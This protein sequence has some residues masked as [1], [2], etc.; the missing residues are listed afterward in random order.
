M[1]IPEGKRVYVDEAC[2][3]QHLLPELPDN[4]SFHR[5]KRLNETEE[6]HKRKIIFL[7]PYPPELNL[8]EYLGHWLK[9]KKAGCLKFCSGLNIALS[10]AI[11]E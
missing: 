10:P 11:Q 2:F 1:E 5:K 7:P 4:A 6:K 3:G 8:I 9:K